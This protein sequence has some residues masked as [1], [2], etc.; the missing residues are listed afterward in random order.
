MALRSRP[1]LLPAAEI[2]TVGANTR[3]QNRN[4]GALNET[5]HTVVC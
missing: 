1:A 5:V 4:N 3:A 2:N